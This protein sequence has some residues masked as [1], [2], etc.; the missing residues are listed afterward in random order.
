MD[1][2]GT[3]FNSFARELGK[4]FLVTTMRYPGDQA[5]TFPALVELVQNALPTSK[6]YVL[7]AESFSTPVAI[8]CAAR[9]D[10]NLKGL[11][12]CAGF[13]HSPVPRWMSPFAALL[14]PAFSLPLPEVVAKRLLLGSTSQQTL[15]AEVRDAVATVKGGVLS[16]RLRMIARCD[17]RRELR[18]TSVP[19]LYIRGTE[20][21]LVGIQSFEDVRRV[22]P[23]TLLAEIKAPH[24]VLQRQPEKAVQK[25]RAFVEQ[26]ARASRAPEGH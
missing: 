11:V 15:L 7:I 16:Q 23:D 2:T 1:G 8:L 24:L 17:V 6:P 9:H 10:P 14:R 20:D 19:L 12:L 4:R 25:V 18:T 3:L 21:R 5:L 22:R 13:A 26:L